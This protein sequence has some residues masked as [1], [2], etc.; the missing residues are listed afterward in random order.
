MIKLKK[1]KP[2][3]IEWLIEWN[4][5][6]YNPWE[7]VPESERICGKKEKPNHRFTPLDNYIS[8]GVNTERPIQKE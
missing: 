5:P 1:L 6:I 7:S 2:F 4:K 8:H 3:G